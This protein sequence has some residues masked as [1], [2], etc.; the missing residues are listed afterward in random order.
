MSASESSYNYVITPAATVFP[1]SLRANLNPYWRGNGKVSFILAVKWS[2]GIAIYILSGRV[3]SQATS[4]VRTKHYGLYPVTN[5]LT[6]P[7]SSGF[8]IYNWA[9]KFLLTSNDPGF[10]KHYPLFTYSLVI[11][12]NSTPTLSPD[13]P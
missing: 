8:K 11:P 10:T 5:G 13:S 9:S 6:L 3:I 7:P 2:P 12:L 1:P 4:A